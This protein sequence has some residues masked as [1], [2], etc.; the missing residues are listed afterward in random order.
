MFVG[1]R[2][3]VAAPTN[4]EPSSGQT[5]MAGVAQISTSNNLQIV[6][7]GSAAQAA[8]DLGVN[9]PANTL[10]A[11]L[12]ELALFAPPDMQV[13]HYQVT[14]VNTGDVATGTL[15][16]AVGTVIPAAT[17]FLAHSVWRCNNATAAAVGIDVVSVYIET[18]N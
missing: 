4:I 8:I 14:R 5:N 12:Y 11:D 15:S 6:Y 9:F 17:T 3:A 10:S 18:D 13:I 1:L 7:G 16:G 2:N